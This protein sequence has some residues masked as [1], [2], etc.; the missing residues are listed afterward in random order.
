VQGKL[1]SWLSG[2]KKGVEVG[3]Q[4]Q[5]LFRA[6]LRNRLTQTL[7]V[8]MASLAIIAEGLAIYINWQEA[9]IKRNEAYKAQIQ[10]DVGRS[11][12]VGTERRRKI[13]CDSPE[14][15]RLGGERCL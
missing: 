7:A 9:I 5:S 1:I 6:I 11:E 8:I 2:S 14:G 10:Y 3:D 4:Q 12:S 15:K 13:L